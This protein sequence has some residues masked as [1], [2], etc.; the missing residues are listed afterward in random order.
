MIISNTSYFRRPPIILEPKQVIAFNGISYSIDI[1]E[2]A[3]LR[4]KESLF[5]SSFPEGA[6]VQSTAIFSDVWTIINN[7]NIFHKLVS[8][9]FKIDRKDPL[10][11]SLNEIEALR[12]SNQHI[13]QRIDEVILS[14]QLPIYG[15]I[16]WYAKEEL[17]SPLGKIITLDSGSF[18]YKSQVTMKPVNPIG[19]SSD[20][21]INVIEFTGI[22]RI[23]SNFITGTINIDDLLVGLKFVIDHLEGQLVEQLKGYEP[24]QR[25][26][27]ELSITLYTRKVTN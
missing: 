18:S 14:Q 12:N 19:K 3:Y 24:L 23:N 11:N 13:D 2:L 7:A 1:C 17:G 25:H 4:L 27:H 6:M 20:E 21:S 22:K 8:T 9:Q 10:F 5:K 15:S 26:N 16:S